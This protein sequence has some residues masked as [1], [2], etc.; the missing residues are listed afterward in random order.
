MGNG[1][2]ENTLHALER[3]H[4]R[5]EM[6]VWVHHEPSLLLKTT[7]E[8]FLCGRKNRATYENG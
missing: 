7:F 1:E 5:E 8:G 4:R 6:V 3:Q 2:G